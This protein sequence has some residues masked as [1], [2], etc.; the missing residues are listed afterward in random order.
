M[1]QTPTNPTQP[2][3]TGNARLM[4]ENKKLTV[5]VRNTGN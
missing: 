1:S 2:P 3:V 4:E 5:P